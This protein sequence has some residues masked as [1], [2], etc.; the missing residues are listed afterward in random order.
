[1]A[2]I[3]ITKIDGYE[4]L[5][6]EEKVKLLESFEYDDGTSEVERYPRRAQMKVW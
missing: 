1:M 4:K 2:K 3:D 6:A 5:S